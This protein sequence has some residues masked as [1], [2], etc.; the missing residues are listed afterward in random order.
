VF[1]LSI[2]LQAAVLSV[3]GVLSFF[4]QTDSTVP[5]NHRT[6][7]RVRDAGNDSELHIRSCVFDVADRSSK[8]DVLWGGQL[9]KA[10]KIVIDDKT[11]AAQ[12]TRWHRA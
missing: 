6:L 1:L 9:A 10:S 8:D 2:A 3:V 7:T 5:F 12:R 11:A 4:W